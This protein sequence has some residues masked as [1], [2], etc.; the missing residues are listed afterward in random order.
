MDCSQ[1]I[2]FNYLQIEVIKSSSPKITWPVNARD[3][4][5]KEIYMAQVPYL[6]IYWAWLVKESTSKNFMASLKAQEKLLQAVR[7]YNI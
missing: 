2:R 4:I 6:W 3:Y 1:N 7:K 5:L